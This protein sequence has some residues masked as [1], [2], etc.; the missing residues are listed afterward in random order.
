[1]VYRAVKETHPELQLITSSLM[2]PLYM[3]AFQSGDLDLALAICRLWALGMP[4]DVG[5]LFSIAR[6]H[7]ARG[8]TE[9]AIQAYRKILEMAPDH[10][11]AGNARAAIE[12]L[13]RTSRDTIPSDIRRH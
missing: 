6:V 3:E 8:E 4:E 12:E 13:G 2:G 10:P 1:M 11:A 9:E 5:P 7:R